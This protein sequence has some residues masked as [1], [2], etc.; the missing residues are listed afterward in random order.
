MCAYRIIF[1][2]SSVNQY[3][4]H[5]YILNIVAMN[6]GILICLQGL[7]FISFVYMP[8]SV[9]PGSYGNSIF[10]VLRNLHPVF[11]N[12]CIN[13]HPYQQYIRVPF[14]P[15][16]SQHLLFVALSMVTTLTGVRWYLTVFWFAFPWLL[17]VIEHLFMYP[18]AICMSSLEKCLFKYFVHFKN[19]VICC[20][21][22]WVLGV[23]DIFS[24]LTSH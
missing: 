20:L 24:V 6:M 21:S 11:L 15:N 1:I 5:F 13:L 3:F 9:I 16:P 12:D 18:L 8:R 19:Q 22:I 4:G 17:I 7:A 10:N 23:L 2:H 14:S